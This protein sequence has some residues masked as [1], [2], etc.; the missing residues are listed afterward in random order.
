MW[1]LSSLAAFALA[2]S[3]SSVAFAQPRHASSTPIGRMPSVEVTDDGLVYTVQSGD[4]VSDIAV[5]FEVR[6]DDLVRWNEGLDPERI[7]EGQTLRIDNGLRR[8]VHRVRRGDRLAT[9][10]S[11]YEVSIDEI[12]RWNHGISPDRIRL[13]SDLVIFTRRPA[14]RSAS[15]G[16]PQTGRLVHARQMPLR[17]PAL[18]VRTPT[19]A[20]G[21]D[22]TVRWLVDA[23][24]AVRS[25]IPRT[26]RVEV[27]DLSRRNGGALDG[28]RSHRSGRDADLAYFQ[29]D[30]RTDCRFRRIGPEDL[31]VERQW[32]LFQ[33][34]LE[35]GQVEAIFVDHA[36]QRALYREARRQGVDRRRLSRWF[37]YPR[38]ADNRYGIIRHHPR[39]AD[40]YHVRFVC[41]ESDPDCR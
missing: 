1:V 8:V 12:V 38:E 41:H 19:R 3:F 23:Y 13:D 39:H 20:F 7:R 22:E 25:E 18:R 33:H 6:I 17:H 40:H 5:R 15:V 21:T 11:Y 27:H 29:R 2:L 34:W 24:E 37:Q 26:P 32:R 28:H 36:L 30:C 16:A 14:S 10:A 31:D 4:T 35:R 9:L